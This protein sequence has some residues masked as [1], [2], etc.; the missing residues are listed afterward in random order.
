M[1]ALEYRLGPH[2]VA[3]GLPRFRRSAASARSGFEDCSKDGNRT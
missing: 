1:F 2:Y 3:I